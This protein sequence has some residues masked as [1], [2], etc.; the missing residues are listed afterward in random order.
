VE[1]VRFSGGEHSGLL[2][3]A[4]A[5]VAERLPLMRFV[6]LAGGQLYDPVEQCRIPGTRVVRRPGRTPAAAA[7]VAPAAA[8]PVA[9]PVVAARGEQEIA[10]AWSDAIRPAARPGPRPAPPGAPVFRSARTAG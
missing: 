3:E 5:E 6:V 9:P 10:S 7:P 4:P 2:V 1:L 8:P